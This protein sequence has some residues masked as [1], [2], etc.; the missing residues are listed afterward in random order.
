M[1]RR[2]LY[3]CSEAVDFLLG[4]GQ[5]PCHDHKIAVGI[6][7]R[8]DQDCGGQDQGSGHALILDDRS[9]KLPS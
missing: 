9:S 5:L 4:A 2:C 1:T 6:G 7:I 3:F 8:D